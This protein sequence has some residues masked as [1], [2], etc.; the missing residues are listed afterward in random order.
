MM[1]RFKALQKMREPD[2]LDSPTLLAAPRGW[3]AVFVVGF[4]LL[5]GGVW[6][7]LGQIP[8]S[9]AAAGL[10]TYSGGT[11]DVQTPEAGTV[12]RVLV[13]VGR[14]ITVGTPLAEIQTSDGTNTLPSPFAG[15]VV[16]IQ[17]SDAAVVERGSPLITVERRQSGQPL[18][19]MLFAPESTSVTLRPGQQVALSVSTAPAA[20]YGLLRATVSTVSPFALTAKE[21]ANLVGGDL[22]AQPYLKDGPPHLVSATLQSDSAT[23]SGLAWTTAAGPPIAVRSQTQVQATVTLGS[24]APL[25]LLFG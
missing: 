9:V 10:L 17:V 18:V 14:Q 25:S 15:T 7:V 21:V 13:E 12:R 8:V 20:V 16:S 2:E 1:F 23:A 22:A 3:I 5:G 6:A 4:V 24:Q 19:A 11:L